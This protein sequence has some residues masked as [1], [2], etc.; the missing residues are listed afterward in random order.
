MSEEIFTNLVVELE[1]DGGKYELIAHVED[2]PP[3]SWDEDSGIRPT[4]QMWWPDPMSGS[5]IYT[6]AQA[7]ALIAALEGCIAHCERAIAEAGRR[8][9]DI[10]G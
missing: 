8:G 7:R 6:V 10:E 2:A 1:D 5:C 3:G 4:V 9:W